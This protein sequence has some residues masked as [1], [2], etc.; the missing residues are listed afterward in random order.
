[1]T[2]SKY[3]VVVAGW[4]NQPGFSVWLRSMR[5]A[6]ISKINSSGSFIAGKPKRIVAI[7]R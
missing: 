1:M 5:S 3:I 6:P 4:P 2:A 7:R